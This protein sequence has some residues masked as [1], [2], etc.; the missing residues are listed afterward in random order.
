MDHPKFALDDIDRSIL[1]H[2]QRNARLSNVELAEKAG[3]S[4]SPCWRRVRALEDTGVIAHYVTLVDPAAVGLPVSVFVNV[5]LERQIESSLEIFE[6]AILE[7]PEVMECYLMTGDADYLLRVVVP[8]LR[9]YEQFLMAH[10]TRVAGISSIRSSFALR[11]VK[12]RTDLPIAAP[13]EAR[14]ATRAR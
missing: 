8:D 13:V 14:R 4:P 7:R 10:L 11:A 3:I 1:A 12:Y 5:S 9:A 2:L 6:K